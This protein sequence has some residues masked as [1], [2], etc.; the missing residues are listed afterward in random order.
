[1][2]SAIPVQRPSAAVLPPTTKP[3]KPLLRRPTL[4][5]TVRKRDEA[6]LD[7]DDVHDESSPT[8]RKKVEFA[9]HVQEKVMEEYVQDAGLVRLE[10]RQAIE[11]HLLG[12]SEGYARV[13]EVFS[14]RPDMED[15]PSAATVKVY[16]LALTSCVAVLSRECNGLVRSVV[17]CEWLGRDEAFVKL[18]VHFLGNLVSAQG[19]YVGVVL[20]MLVSKFTSGKQ[21]RNQLVSFGN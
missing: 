11:Q 17:E 13:K 2:V 6:G 21:S 19:S 14:M 1:M 10:V 9:A 3:I 16:I 20:S 5:G 7:D 4:A 8:K 15:A 18:Y 12:D